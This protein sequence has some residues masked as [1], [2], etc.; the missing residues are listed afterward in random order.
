MPFAIDQLARS[1]R[2]IENKKFSIDWGGGKRE[3][4]G[5]PFPLKQSYHGYSPPTSCVNNV[6]VRTN[7][8]IIVWSYTVGNMLLD[9]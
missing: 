3:G 4:R 5:G 7:G 9:Q 8:G 6:A 2:G 1:I